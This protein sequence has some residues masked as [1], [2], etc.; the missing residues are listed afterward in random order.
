MLNDGKG[1][2]MLNNSGNLKN[3]D[4]NLIYECP[5]ENS[6]HVKW[7]EER[8]EVELSINPGD[9]DLGEGKKDISIDVAPEH[10][11]YLIEKLTKLKESIPVQYL[12]R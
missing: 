2:F 5:S 11:D 9:Y 6:L 12:K 1:N 4:S 10:L 3:K 7:N 8:G